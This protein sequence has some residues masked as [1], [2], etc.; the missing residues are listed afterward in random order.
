MTERVILGRQP[1]GSYGLRASLPGVSA[2]TASDSQLAFNYNWPDVG[3]VWATGIAILNSTVSFTA[4]PFVPLVIG[5]GCDLN[6]NVP[7][8]ANTNEG[9][10]DP[11]M[12]AFQNRVEFVKPPSSASYV[13]QA[14]ITHCRYAVLTQ[15]LF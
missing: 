4:L 15:A 13:F 2:L 12:R 8:R 3:L 1:D 7:P 10:Q 5:I 14:S 9:W 11:Q 6:G